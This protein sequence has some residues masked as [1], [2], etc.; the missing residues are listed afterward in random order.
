M[1]FWQLRP[2]WWV[3]SPEVFFTSEEPPLSRYKAWML[4]ELWQALQGTG[5]CRLSLTDMKSKRK[6]WELE[7]HLE[8][9]HALFPN[10]C[11]GWLLWASSEYIMQQTPRPMGPRHLLLKMA[12]TVSKDGVGDAAAEEVPGPNASSRVIWSAMKKTGGGGQTTLNNALPF[13]QW[14]QKDW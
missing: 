7:G 11:H 2:L 5:S 9:F 3:H 14:P 6:A 1:R 10:A 13:N 4:R 8:Q 12:S